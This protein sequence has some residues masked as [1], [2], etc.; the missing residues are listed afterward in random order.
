MHTIC[1]KNTFIHVLEPEN[2]KALKG[3]CSYPPS[4]RDRGGPVL[5]LAQLDTL[6]T[7]PSVRK[8]V[9]APVPFTEL[10]SSRSEVTPCSGE[11]QSA[12]KKGSRAKRP[13]RGKRLRYNRLL[14]RM[15]AHVEQDPTSFTLGDLALPPSLIGNPKRYQLFQAQMQ[16]YQ[17]QISVGERPT[18]IPTDVQTAGHRL[19]CK[20]RAAQW[21]QIDDLRNP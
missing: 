12:R 4:P 21:L 7:L 9:N 3:Y 6:P 17:H 19:P 2:R 16:W 8:C 20:A 1:V 5:E 14:L 18:C 13:C 15:C 11:A 10:K